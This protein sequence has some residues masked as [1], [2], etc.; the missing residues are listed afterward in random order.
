MT[1]QVVYSPRAHRQLRD[2]YDW[3]ADAGAPER[4]ERFVSAIYDFCDD[5]ATF[6]LIGVARDD[7]LP[8]LRTIGFRRRATIALV[9]T[10]ATVE[11]HGV[12]YGGRDY[13]AL[14]QGSRD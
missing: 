8:G 4:G 12:Y 1:L 6:P 3:I 14:I 9:V 2:L 13:E 11:I 5:L 10:D 7:L